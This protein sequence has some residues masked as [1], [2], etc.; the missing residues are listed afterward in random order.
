MKK[1]LNFKVFAL[2]EKKSPE[3]RSKKIH[4]STFIEKCRLAEVEVAASEVGP[5]EE[6]AV[7]EAVVASVGAEECVMK[8]H[9]TWL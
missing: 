5:P 3:S 6:E 2:K 8:V 1:A 9:L 7:A 4:P